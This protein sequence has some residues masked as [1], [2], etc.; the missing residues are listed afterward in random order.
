M[1]Y[2]FLIDGAAGD[3][4]RAII[5]TLAQTSLPWLS[6][7][8]LIKKESSREKRSDYDDIWGYN[9]RKDR[10][11]TKNDIIERYCNYENG[12]EEVTKRY[13]CYE[14]PDLDED[15]II[16]LGISKQ[17][18][19]IDKKDINDFIKSTNYN[20]GFLIVRNQ[21]IIKKIISDYSGKVVVVPVYVHTDLYCIEHGKYKSDLEIKQALAKAQKV[22]K[23]YLITSQNNYK[24]INYEEVLIYAVRNYAH[25]EEKEKSYNLLYDEA[26][27]SINT[28]IIKML[29]ERNV[30]NDKPQIFVVMPFRTTNDNGEDISIDN[31]SFLLGVNNTLQSLKNKID[32]SPSTASMSCCYNEV[33]Q[34]K[35]FK[36]IEKADLVIVDLRESLVNCYYELA[37]AR[38]LKKQIIVLY[39]D[40]KM[41]SSIPFDESPFPRFVYHLDEFDKPASFCPELYKKV[42]SVIGLSKNSK[43]D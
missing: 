36:E 3:A 20:Y 19:S 35:I 28:Q 16:K 2:L 12:V 41:N 39:P 29:S 7:S 1:K 14:Y 34:K 40:A 9:D 10:V 30:Y 21:N 11:Y 24:A 37:Y 38:A 8:C 15:L 43:E 13:Y 32:I 42:I 33:M 4:K 26:K 18:Y 27:A 31:Q 22:F 17:Y 25:L 5:S 23:D 6:A